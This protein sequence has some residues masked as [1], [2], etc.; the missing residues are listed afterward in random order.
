MGWNN[1]GHAITV[2]KDCGKRYPGCHSHCQEY[3]EEK[4]I[5]DAKKA[6]YNKKADVYSAI[7]ANRSNQVYKALRKRRK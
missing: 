7:Y 1:T 5:Y 3:I 2:C 6:E 4:A